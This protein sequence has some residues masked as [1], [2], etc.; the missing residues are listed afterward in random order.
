MLKKKEE[1]KKVKIAKASIKMTP[2]THYVKKSEEKK[3]F[4]IKQNLNN[5]NFFWRKFSVV[6][7]KGGLYTQWQCDG[8]RCKC[9]TLN[10]VFSQLYYV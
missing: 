9:V 10:T 7:C 4:K 2:L 5:G 8:F 6:H 1:K 3:L